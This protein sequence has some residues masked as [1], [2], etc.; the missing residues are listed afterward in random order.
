M[1]IFVFEKAFLFFLTK[2][3]LARYSFIVFRRDQK[4]LLRFFSCQAGGCS[5]IR[6]VDLCLSLLF[7][8]DHL[9]L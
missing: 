2:I 5:A 3:F 8:G 4:V 6:D 9:M 7:A 1:E